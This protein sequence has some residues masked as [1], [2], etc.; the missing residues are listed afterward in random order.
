MNGLSTVEKPS[1]QSTIEQVEKENNSNDAPVVEYGDHQTDDNDADVS[2]PTSKQISS[3]MSTAIVVR[4]EN[5]SRGY[6]PMTIWEILL[7]IMGFG[8]NGNN[9]SAP[10]SGSGSSHS[11]PA[12]IV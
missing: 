5:G 1:V 6:L 12:M 9:T 8:S 7:R 3:G 10:R 4:Q 2:I 11:I